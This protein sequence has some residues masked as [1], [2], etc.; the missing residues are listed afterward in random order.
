MIQDRTIDR[1]ICAQGQLLWSQYRRE[2][3]FGRQSPPAADEP[4]T[5]SELSTYCDHI[6][7]CTIC[8][9]G[10]DG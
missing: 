5:E 8:S 1:Q 3:P 9:K 4:C 7:N 6:K 2:R 10:K